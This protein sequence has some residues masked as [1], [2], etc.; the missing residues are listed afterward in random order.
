MLEDDFLVMISIPP[1]I[2][3]S[4]SNGP[5]VPIR[6]L[7]SNFSTEAVLA[8]LMLHNL[9][10][11]VCLR[12]FVFE[13]SYLSTRLSVSVQERF[14]FKWFDGSAF[15]RAPDCPE[16]ARLCQARCPKLVSKACVKAYFRSLSSWKTTCS[17]EL[18]KACDRD[19]PKSMRAAVATQDDAGYGNGLLV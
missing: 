17:E 9:C 16:E 4:L 7:R 18:S 2:S 10:S 13:G 1:V 14:C 6:R 19:L 5:C 15:G 8:E 12:E 11:R 3:P